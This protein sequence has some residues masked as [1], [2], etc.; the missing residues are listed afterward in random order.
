MYVLDLVDIPD[1]VI[2]ALHDD[3]RLLACYFSAGS[4][5]PWRDDVA[6]LPADVRGEPLPEHPDERWLDV[7]RTEVHDLVRA[8]LDRAVARGCDGVDP[9]NLDAYQFTSGFP[10]TEEDQRGFDRF[11]LN[12]AHLRGL[13]VALQD[14]LPQ[15]PD[16]VDYADLAIVERC[17]E[18]GTCDGLAPFADAGK[19][20]LDAEYLPAYLA[21]P[22]GFCREAI[23]AGT[24]SLILDPALDDSVRVACDTDFPETSRLA[25][26]LTYTTYYGRDGADI[27]ALRGLD[28]AIV[29][30]L[31]TADQ[32]AA[33]QATTKLAVY[34]SIG[35]I[36]LSNTY[37]K[38]TA[39]RSSG[40][41]STTRTPSGSSRRTR[42]ST[43][44]S[45]TATRRA[46]A[47]SSGGRRICC[48]PRA[49]TGCSST[50]STRST[51]TRRSSP[52]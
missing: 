12:E 20:I 13:F 39:R 16:L 35:E 6:G 17:H 36:G 40:R 43:P 44:G 38:S 25:G 15:V 29:Q 8:R 47:T 49:T 2:S 28:L 27:D 34:L 9:D 30:P 50:P 41:P 19:P 31:L 23:V 7:R 48:S 46:G 3:G 11:V 33:L 14:D 4:Y 1:A 32:R 10:L 18:L 45:P 37:L 26:T 51:C 24:R 21:D 42:S 52:A 22:A 5:E